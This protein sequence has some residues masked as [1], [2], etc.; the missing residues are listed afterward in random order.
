MREQSRLNTQLRRNST[1]YIIN[2]PLITAVCGTNI[3]IVK[4]ASKRPIGKTHRLSNPK[5]F[6]GRTAASSFKI[7]G[8]TDATI[9]KRHKSDRI[10]Q[11]ASSILFT[12][13]YHNI[14][15]HKISIISNNDECG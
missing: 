6:K 12:N 5:S 4:T 3:Q 1:P 11:Q 7:F 9:K 13:L 14:T 8:V 15:F 2:T 10:I